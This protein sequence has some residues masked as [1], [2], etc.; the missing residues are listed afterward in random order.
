MNCAT[1]LVSG[2]LASQSAIKA[3]S[4]LIPLSFMSAFVMICLI[5]IYRPHLEPALVRSDMSMMKAWRSKL[6]KTALRPFASI[7]KK[8]YILQMSDVPTSRKVEGHF[9]LWLAYS[10]L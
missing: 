6:L 4:R 7:L 9:I 5:N 3:L 10:L 2:R 8:R 1:L